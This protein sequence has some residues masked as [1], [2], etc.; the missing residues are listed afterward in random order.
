MY[1]APHTRVRA[2]A[3]TALAAS[4]PKVLAQYQG[5]LARKAGLREA[6]FSAFTVSGD[7]M[8]GLAALTP[9]SADTSPVP[10]A[11]TGSELAIAS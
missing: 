11:A 4:A 6:A 9:K 2:A 1:D 5:L 3:K 7:A 8:K 10:K